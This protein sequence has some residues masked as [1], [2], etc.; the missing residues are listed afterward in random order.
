MDLRTVLARSP[1]GQQDMSG[2]NPMRLRELFLAAREM[3]PG[4]RHAFV[5]AACPD[6]PALQAELL[7]L[8]RATPIEDRSLDLGGMLEHVRAHVPAAAMNEQFGRFTLLRRLGAGGMGRVDLAFDPRSQRE[9][10]I[11]RPTSGL[12]TED[13]VA[14]F[15][16]ERRA[17][18]KM[19]GLGLCPIYEVGEIDGTPYF[20]MPFLTG[21][22]L[23]E[24]LRRSPGR[25]PKSE[26]LWFVALFEKVSHALHRAHEAGL[27][28]RDIKPANIMIRPNGEPVVLDF[29]LV[30]DQQYA[31]Q[32]LTQSGQLPGTPSYM[33]PEQIAGLRA[34]RRTDVY[35][36]GIA[37]YE[38][39]CGNVPFAGESR[40]ELFEQIRNRPLPQPRRRNRAIPRALAA[41]L[42]VATHKDPDHRYLTAQA[43]AE[44]LLRV[45]LQQPVQA[46]RMPAWLRIRQWCTRNRLAS[47][48]IAS[49]AV[50]LVATGLLEYERATLN[51]S[52]RGEIEKE[53]SARSAAERQREIAQQQ[54][55][56]FRGL[57]TI[58]RTQQALA[59]E[60]LLY[61][62][63][64]NQA[65]ALAAWLTV[66]GTEMQRDLEHVTATLAHL[67]R[68][69]EARLAVRVAPVTPQ[70][71]LR[72]ELEQLDS[73][74]AA[75]STAR[76]VR[77]GKRPLPATELPEH[78]PKQAAALLAAAWSW[79][80]PER[81]ASRCGHESLAMAY[82]TRALELLAPDPPPYE[83]LHAMLWALVATGAD[84]NEEFPA[85]I[86]EP[87]TAA[88]ALPGD[89]LRYCTAVQR[90]DA[91]RRRADHDLHQAEAR[92]TEVQRQ[93]EFPWLPGLT[94]SERVLERELR[95]AQTEL[96][97]HLG[98]GGLVQQVAQRRTWAE[99]IDALTRSHPNA[100]VTW[101]QAATAIR[102]ADGRTAS[103]AYAS[104][105]IVLEPVEGLVPIGMNPQTKL[106]E[107]YHL[108]SAYDPRLGAEPA[109]L[110]IPEHRPD[111]SI[112]LRPDLG[113]IFV[114]LP[115]GP[116]VAG[117]QSRDPNGHNYDAKCPPEQKIVETRIAP[118][119]MAR[120]ELTQGQWMRLSLCDNPSAVAA[121]NP[122]LGVVITTLHPVENIT[123][124]QSTELLAQSGLRLPGEWE[125]QYA[126]RAGTTTPWSSGPKEA[127]LAGRAN[128]LGLEWGNQRGLVPFDDGHR[129]HAPVGSYVPNAFGLFDVHG[130][131]GEYCTAN[132]PRWESIAIAAGGDVMSDALKA[133]SYEA[134]EQDPET[135]TDTS[136]TTGLR[137]ARTFP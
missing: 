110:A 3:E 36:L 82:L 61:P 106:W 2:V 26:V 112:E 42:E 38:C 9:V 84:R 18:S 122:A 134:S 17:A 90:A 11:K 50:G 58:Q 4:A 102:T 32:R 68:R 15:E 91:A 116:S 23:S 41:V 133:R 5:A 20:V 57:A 56:D 136:G 6:D 54:L 31:D 8:L 22:S 124:R 135:I 114:L 7:E 118:F 96:Q 73:V 78:A 129:Y 85:S 95:R 14:R 49:L 88:P 40:L 34:D 109:T 46:R 33:A 92:R 120:H 108:R 87:L 70:G 67:R 48:A 12:G 10:A 126:C 39:A 62:S 76:E 123:W 44:D 13:L 69:A 53:Q 65:P 80:D 119:F 103:T 93:L 117:A 98:P 79:V 86:T 113:I 72:S 52:I 59:A 121:G 55:D 100:R 16:R 125:W 71:D 25:R 104:S 132:S 35:A 29:G 130:N 105:G 1:I 131:I 137:A 101:E 24:Q 27:V 75:L 51:E 99:S 74:I 107:F 89:P 28:H 47:T 127:D 66:H 30:Q 21:E 128:L 81:P 94:D 77:T 64:P 83:A 97:H 37:L 111:G 63:R 19:D 45:R 60:R 43:F 115:G